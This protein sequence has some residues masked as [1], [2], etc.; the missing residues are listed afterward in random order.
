MILWIPLL[1]KRLELIF[2][3]KKKV[4]EFK[5]KKLNNG[6]EM[7]KTKIFKRYLIWI[8]FGIYYPKNK[9]LGLL[10]PKNTKMSL[11]N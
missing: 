11:S 3:L 9:L 10:M 8:K 1:I 4:S 7:V 6:A 5:E 2:R